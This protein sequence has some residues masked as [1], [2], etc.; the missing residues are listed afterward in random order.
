MQANRTIRNEADQM[1]VVTQTLVDK[2]E[3]DG[4]HFFNYSGKVVN[5]SNRVLKRAELVAHYLYGSLT[6]GLHKVHEN[7]NGYMLPAGTTLQPGQS[8]DFAYAHSYGEA[9]IFVLSYEF[10]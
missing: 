8:I 6:G 7:G 5:E 10:E 2:F 1:V 4:K 3:Q 9:Q